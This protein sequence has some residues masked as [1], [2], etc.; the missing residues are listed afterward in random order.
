MQEIINLIKVD[1]ENALIGLGVLLVC[2]ITNMVLG[3]VMSATVGEF[4][5]KR[6]LK[7]IIK[8]ILIA[9]SMLVFV[10]VLNIIPLWLERINL[11]NASPLKDVIN[12]I[13]VITI[14][15]VSITKYCKEIYDKLLTLFDVKEEEVKQF[16][17]QYYE[18][19]VI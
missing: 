9:L 3:A 4:D 13:Q 19:E 14:L 5:F 6:F 10:I 8:G 12:V 17:T 11:I 1:L 7:S 2:Y 16:S 15:V 18:G